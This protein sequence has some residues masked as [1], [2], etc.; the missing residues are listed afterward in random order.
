MRRLIE[1]SSKARV[2]LDPQRTA[3]AA[4]GVHSRS[5]TARRSAA[6]LRALANLDVG[7]ARIDVAELA[8]EVWAEFGPGEEQPLGY[9]SRCY[10]GAPYEV[11]VLD[12]AGQVVEHYE[13]GRA[14][15]V[16]YSAGH[17]LALHPAYVAVE[18]YPT[19]VMGVREDGSV[20]DITG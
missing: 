4:G 1:L 20:T 3:T 7:G 2:G 13:V 14:L 15:P 18:I 12:L 8:A 9:V 17:R 19:R 5:R 6:Y 11:H 10:L 16:P